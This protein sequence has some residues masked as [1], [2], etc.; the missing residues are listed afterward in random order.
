M[1]LTEG[2]AKE[3][4]RLGG[5]Q[6]TLAAFRAFPTNVEIATNC[7]SALWSLAIDGILYSF[8]NTIFCR[9]NIGCYFNRYIFVVIF[10]NG[11]QCYLF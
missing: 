1:F 2:A 3:I 7:C 6:D 10:Y 8:S 5:V 9:M 4:G 11:M